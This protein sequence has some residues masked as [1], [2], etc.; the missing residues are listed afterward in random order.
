MRRAGQARH[1]SAR[2]R[3]AVR[4]TAAFLALLGSVAI[5]ACG[6]SASGRITASRASRLARWTEFARVRR[7]LDLAGPRRNGSLLL[8]VDA[9]LSLLTPGGGVEPF[10]SRPGAYRSPGGEEPYIALSPGGC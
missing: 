4:P 2:A 5:S 7:P 3:A 9:Q 6:S 1:R 8:A 10:A